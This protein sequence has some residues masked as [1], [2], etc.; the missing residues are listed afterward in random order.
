MQKNLLR[1]CAICTLCGILYLYLIMSKSSNKLLEVA[2]ILIAIMGFYWV[3]RLLQNRM[4]FHGKRTKIFLCI[5]TI[6]ITLGSSGLF[7]QAC[8]EMFTNDV[9]I[10]VRC[11]QKNESAK[12]AEVSIYKYI[13]DG[14]QESASSLE[15]VS[16]VN[17]GWDEKNSRYLYV[18]SDGSGYGEMVFRVP[19][20]KQCSILFDR[21]SYCGIV[22]ISNNVNSDE[23]RKDLYLDAVSTYLYNVPTTMPL[24]LKDIALL[25]TLCAVCLVFPSYILASLLTVLYLSFKDVIYKQKKCDWASI[26]LGLSCALLPLAYILF[27][28]T[29]NSGE[30]QFI[31]AIRICAILTVISCATYILIRLATRSNLIGYVITFLVLISIFV[32]NHIQNIM[33]KSLDG[34]NVF[35]ILIGICCLIMMILGRWRTKMKLPLIV[36]SGILFFS[37]MLCSFSLPKCLSIYNQQRNSNGEEYIKKTFNTEMVGIEDVPNIYWIHVDGMLGFDAFE[38][39]F[40]DD[41]YQFA[42]EL[43]SRGFEINRHAYFSAGHF[44]NSCVP[45]LFCPDFYDSYIQPRVESDVDYDFLVRDTQDA[46]A[47]KTQNILSMLRCNTEIG[48]ALRKANYN[49]TLSAP[50]FASFYFGDKDHHFY[51][52]GNGI[53]CDSQTHTANN[54]ILPSD[55]SAMFIS[56]FMQPLSSIYSSLFSTQQEKV[57]G[58]VQS[59]DVDTASGNSILAV[60]AKQAIELSNPPFLSLIYFNECHTPFD[61]NQYG[62]IVRE[63]STNVFD[64]PEAHK[65]ETKVIIK[66]LDAILAKDPDAIIIIQGDHGLHGNTEQDFQAAF[67]ADA[68][69][70]ELWNC[71]MS[72]VRIPEKYRSGE[73]EYAFTNPLNISRYLVNRFVGQNYEYLPANTPIK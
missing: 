48:T 32:S 57:V 19:G 38:K 50:S 66:M 41:Q 53:L 54:V 1:V 43:T 26:V 51:T 30:I 71:V 8:P 4:S 46:Q 23:I 68:S 45:A 7:Y 42:Q 55:N 11:G 33:P 29:T 37:I 3:S 34:V 59:S 47:V 28:F 13:I 36:A 73:E 6:I 67:G 35:L 10:T 52:P 12:S 9:L 22:E 5:L 63:D 27:L 62:E 18:N 20:G 39:Y 49:I 17:A 40:N 70:D 44:T 61:I 24:P 64:Y 16:S 31:V 72:A 56:T 25:L 69:A 21:H 2:F 14:V 15:L 60:I 65:Y 58:I